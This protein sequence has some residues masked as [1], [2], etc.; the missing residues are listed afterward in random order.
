MKKIGILLSLVFVFSV[1]CAGQIIIKEKGPHIG[2]SGS[3][4]TKC[5]GYGTGRRCENYR[6]YP[7]YWKSRYQGYN[8]GIWPH[9][10][11]GK[12]G[13]TKSDGTRVE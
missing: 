7:A 1:S 11:G 13:Y 6:F 4:I 10:P 3:G 5:Y 8:V 9:C 2:R 12:I